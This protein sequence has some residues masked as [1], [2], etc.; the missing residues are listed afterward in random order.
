VNL[1]FTTYHDYLAELPKDGKHLM[2]QQTDD[3]ILVFQAFN[4]QIADFALEHQ[5]FG[6]AF[7][8]YSRMSWVK[9]SFLW[10][11]DRCGWVTKEHQERVLGIW[12]AKTDF[13]YILSQSVFSSFNE[14]QYANRD[15]WKNELS[16]KQVRLQ[17]DPDRDVYGHKLEH[18]AIQLGL[19]STILQTFGNEMIKGIMDLTTFAQQQKQ[20]LKM[21][22]MSEILLPKATVYLPE[23]KNLISQIGLTQP[24]V[25]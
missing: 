7:Y 20:H 12:I 24:S 13:D 25:N 3:S 18:K 6:G 9:L 21:K 22:Q 11:M 8:S 16:K 5:Y 10:M 1:D 2:G 19:K 17:W 4:K 15:A 14:T 23:D